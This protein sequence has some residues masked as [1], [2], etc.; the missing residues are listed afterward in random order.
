N[1]LVRLTLARHLAWLSIH[2]ELA[3]EASQ[4]TFADATR[5]LDG[6]AALLAQIPSAEMSE[7][8]REVLSR[9]AIEVLEYR[10]IICDKFEDHAGAEAFFKQMAEKARAIGWERA[11]VDAA[12][13]WAET[14]RIQR[15]YTK[16]QQIL[17][18]VLPRAEQLDDRR[19]IAFHKRAR[20]R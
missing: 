10:G 13:R 8:E 9:E 14:A 3:A 17:D 2:L 11:C 20:A 7:R 15:N 12:I 16:A 1:P 18:D 4:K 5:W 6:H 19:V